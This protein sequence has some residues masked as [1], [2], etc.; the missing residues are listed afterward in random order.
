MIEEL[1]Q[2]FIFKGVMSIGDIFNIELLN[3]TSMIP[4]EYL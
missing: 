3:G 1:K 2:N 4:D